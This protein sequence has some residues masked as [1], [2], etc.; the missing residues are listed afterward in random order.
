MS[1]A[2][3]SKL[4]RYIISEFWLPLASGV[5][6]ITG[7]WLGIDKFKEVFRL[8]AKSG[9][10]LDKG[11]VIIGLQIPEILSMTTPI[12]VLLASFLV[13]QKLSGQSEILAMRAAG[14]SFVRILKPVVILGALMAILTFI[15]SEFVVPM[16]SPLARQMYVLAL[17]K[18][19]MPMKSTRD[20][21]YFE[22]DGRKRIKRIFYV[23]SFK[24]ETLRDV[25]V[26]DFSKK[27]LSQIY[28]A[29]K[30]EWSPKQGGWLLERGNSHFIQQ[31]DKEGN[32]SV[33]LVSTFD[34]TFIPSGINPR[35]I[36]DKITKFRDM[37]FL[38][39]KE[40]IDL[41]GNGSIE[42]SKISEAWTKF[43]NKFAYPIS[44]ILL[45]LMGACLGIIGRRRTINWGYIFL[46]LIVF[47]FY[48]SQTVFLSFGESGKI[49]PF[50]T[51]WI[52]NLIIGALTAFAVWYRTELK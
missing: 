33:D 19:P 28:T 20:F 50:I 13:F 3:L 41:H 39:L 27:G 25:I 37:N 16:A 30:G 15:M 14:A 5:G 18:D 12:G 29:S 31:R 42:T 47:V 2:L 44:C 51:V 49:D 45:A 52:P 6:V 10:S 11:I 48:M 21:S 17:Y 4:D 24:E 32:K 22:K 7:V 38:A 34:T 8:L 35:K 43:H 23:R 1:K 36:L 9:A 46:G 40:F 26:L